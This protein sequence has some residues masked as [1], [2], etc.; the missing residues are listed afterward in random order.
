MFCWPVPQ[1]KPLTVWTYPA[2]IPWSAFFAPVKIPTA[3]TEFFLVTRSTPF[4]TPVSMLAMKGLGL[5]NMNK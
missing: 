3:I 1:P 5:G 4:K 2:K